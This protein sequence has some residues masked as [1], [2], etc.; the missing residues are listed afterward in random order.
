MAFPIV[1]LLDNF[2]RA[3][4]ATLG[5]NWSTA[6]E[7]GSLQIVSNQCAVVNEASTKGNYW[8]VTTFSGDVE[9]YF[10]VVV[11]PAASRFVILYAN[12]NISFTTGYKVRVTDTDILL[13]R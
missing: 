13:M 12:A 2:N 7:H 11:A 5:S 8:N 9:A 1:P 6:E 3:D 4:S 10:T